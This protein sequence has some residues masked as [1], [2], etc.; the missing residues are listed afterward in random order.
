MDSGKLLGEFLQARRKLVT[1]DEIGLKHSGRRRTPGLRREEM[2]F[3]AGVSTDYYSRLEQGRERNPSDQVLAAL[4]RA[5]D[6]D[7]ES[8]QH[9]YALA[10]PRTRRD[11]P[12]SRMESVSPMLLRLLRGWNHTPAMVLGRWMDVLA[13]NPIAEALYDGLQH[14]DNLIRMVF[15]NPAS[16]EFYADWEKIAYHKAAHLRAVAGTDP[17]DPFLPELVEELSEASEEFRRLWARH[18]VHFKTADFKQFHHRGVG[19]LHLFYESFTVNSAPGQQLMIFQAEPGSQ[20]EKALAVLG[21][22][23]SVTAVVSDAIVPAPALTP[24]PART[25]VK[26]S[27]TAR[28][29]GGRDLVESEAKEISARRAM[30]QSAW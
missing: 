17:D 24:A 22:L 9:L 28:G 13:A 26:A 19:E 1:P 6:L 4:A 5:L 21:G 14:N 3:L 2:A 18:D 25:P 12:V 15:L 16:Q 23:S 10:H 29:S 27:V 20:T 11:T 8:A 7:S 30:W